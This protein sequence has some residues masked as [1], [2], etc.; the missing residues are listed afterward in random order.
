MRRLAGLAIDGWRDLAARDWSHDDPD[1]RI[2][3]KLLD[4][5][6]GSVAVRQM[7]GRWIGG[8][9]GL[10]APHGRGPGWGQV[11]ASERR[12]PLA[13]EF[14][15]LLQGREFQWPLAVGAA[16]EALAFGAMDVIV[17]VPDRPELDETAQGRLL[18]AFSKGHRRCRLLWRPVALFL[19]ALHTGAIPA[20]AVGSQFRIVVHAADGLEVQILR[21]RAD[22]DNPS[23]LAPERGGW[24]RVTHPSLGLERLCKELE[25][26]VRAQSPELRRSGTE[27]SRL[28][29][30]LL[31]GRAAPED[32]EILRLANGNW[33][34]ITAP[35]VDPEVILDAGTD[36][37]TSD[38]VAMT[39]FATP[40]EGAFA[41]RFETE[42]RLVWPSAAPL[43]W[44][45][46]AYG[47]LRAGRLIERGFPHY[48]DRLERVALAV[49]GGSDPRFEDLIPPH[50]TVPAN[51]EYVSPPLGGFWW[52]SQKHE[53]DFYVL[54]GGQEV[55]HWKVSRDSGPNKAAPVELRLRQTP[56]QSWA[57]LTISSPEWEPLRRSPV[58]L[59]WEA[60]T[61]LDKSREEV[62]EELRLPPPPVPERVV[63]PPHPWFWQSG[64]W[65][66]EGL[67]DL[68]LDKGATLSA[69][70][71]HLSRVQRLP[72]GKLRVRPIGTDGDLP[73]GLSAA[74][75]DRLAALLDGAARRVVSAGPASPL[76][77]NDA[78]RCVSW[79]FTR[80]P[81]LAKDAL[82]E[83]LEAAAEGLGHPLLSPRFG[84][85]VVLQACGRALDGVE[86]LSR[87]LHALARM[88]I[89]TDV[90]A[91]L[92]LILTR[93]AEAPQALDDALV[94]RL[95]EAL[96]AELAA[97]VGARAFKQRF[98]NTLSA[99]FGL[100]RWRAVQPWALIATRE[101]VAA[102]ARVTVAHALDQIGGQG[103]AIRQG[104]QKVDRLRAL[105]DFLD[106]RGDPKILIVLETD[107]EDGEDVG[108]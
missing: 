73:P 2:D 29:L 38:T 14:A 31:C 35:A 41:K 15:H 87:A 7:D 36:P 20:S 37:D 5:S 65:Y 103:M 64:Q 77:D 25:A 96:V 104:Q 62:L 74:V 70:V 94:A 92:Q 82:V 56:G 99:L 101:P 42:I 95:F 63:E 93:R 80:C 45:A 39:L 98:T 78:T 10:E 89:N 3:P 23:H 68:L 8:P 17:A 12:I 60:L 76:R 100:F 97:S 81:E 28:P 107:T 27:R 86:R 72:D 34:K 59:D 22:P 11:G 88:P 21:L 85:R 16:V 57:K 53:I 69:V 108:D 84:R 58:Q 26:A 51:R 91:A 46:L 24:G 90:V 54:K 71:R 55:R 83:A 66:D 105:L 4:G 18:A 52:A 49:M 61:P 32:P 33:L 13:P 44:D 48:F 67:S 47:A 30:A 9:Q 40:L 102:G 6:L 50:A 106:G 43:P 79:A 75:A 19:E 1:Q